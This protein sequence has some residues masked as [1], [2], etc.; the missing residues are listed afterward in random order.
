[1]VVG[2]L[3]VIADELTIDAT[4]VP[5]AKPEPVIGQP[6]NSTSVFCILITFMLV[7]VSPVNATLPWPAAHEAAEIVRVAATPGIVAVPTVA[8]DVRPGDVDRNPKWP[9]IEYGE[10]HTI[11]SAALGITNAPAE[12]NPEEAEFPPASTA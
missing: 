10:V 9:N 1:V 2:R 12:L 7:L 5:V 4:T 8:V 11:S 3:S 6:T